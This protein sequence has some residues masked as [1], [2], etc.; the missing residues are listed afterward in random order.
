MARSAEQGAETLVWLAASPDV[1]RTSGGY[2]VDMEWGPPSPK[3]RTWQRLGDCGRSAR[4]SVRAL[5]RVS[6]HDA[7]CT[8]AAA[9]FAH[10]QGGR[11][12][13]QRTRAALPA[14]D[15]A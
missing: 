8:A 9:M 13:F 11:C 14:S 1:A 15:R 4:R 5:L 10:R 6:A 2:C 3:D 12:P 7:A